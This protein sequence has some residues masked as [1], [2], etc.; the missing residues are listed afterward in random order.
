MCFPR[1]TRREKSTSVSERNEVEAGIISIDG[2]HGQSCCG[3]DES[4]SDVGRQRIVS[5]VAFTAVF[6][7]ITP[8]TTS[9]SKSS[10]I[11]V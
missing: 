8:V 6:S 9:Q 3:K 11:C 7:A 2:R 5:V 10:L 1:L 4:V